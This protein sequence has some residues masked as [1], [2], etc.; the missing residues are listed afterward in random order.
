MQ[1]IY[2]STHRH[3]ASLCCSPR[4]DSVKYFNCLDI[5]SMLQNLYEF[6]V[7]M[8]MK[9]LAYVQYERGGG[10]RELL[11]NGFIVVIAH[12]TA[13]EMVIAYIMEDLI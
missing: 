2:N 9:A 13:H 12:T 7:F 6:N 3:T 1:F 11:A 10:V 8:W 5:D 4:Q